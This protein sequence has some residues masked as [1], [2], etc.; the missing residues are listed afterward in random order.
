[1]LKASEIRSLKK[2]YSILG[3]KM[4]NMPLY[5]LTAEIY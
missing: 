2:E 1:M 4:L 5:A 3:P